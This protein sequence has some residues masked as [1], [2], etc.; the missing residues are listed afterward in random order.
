MKL[1]VVTTVY[2]SSEH[3]IEFYHRM[4]KVAKK[5]SKDD[6]EIIFVNDGSTEKDLEMI[7]QLSL[8]DHH[9]VTIDL[10][11]N[12]GHHQALL[13]GIKE[14]SGDSVFLIDSDLEEEPEWLELFCNEAKNLK[15]VDIFLGQQIKRRGNFFERLPGQIFFFVVKTFLDRRI[16]SNVTT[17]SLMTRRYVSSLIKFEEVD[18]NL[19][20]LIILNGYKKK[21]IKVTKNLSS[22]STYTLLHKLNILLNTITT[23]SSKPLTFIFVTGMI[24]SFTSFLFLT[25]IIIQKQLMDISIDGWTSLIVSIWFIGGVLMLFLGIIGFYL[26]KIFLETKKRPQS[27]IRNTI[28]NKKIT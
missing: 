1:S 5:V 28:K 27:I 2:Q 25:Y 10:S 4:S 17:A 19:A 23:L 15:D 22:K 13:I 8:S 11:R 26:H 24:I 9:L 21:I 20:T 14:S 6:Y 16:I 7:S 12:F 18:V 3:I